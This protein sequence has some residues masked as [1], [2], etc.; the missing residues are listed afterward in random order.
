MSASEGLPRWARMWAWPWAPWSGPPWGPAR[1]PQK[2]APSD[3][4]FRGGQ[5]IV[6]R[7]PRVRLGK[8]GE[9]IGAGVRGL[10]SWA[11]TWATRWAR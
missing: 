9:C 5:V 8:G 6:I 10:P 11:Q 3:N 4:G 1:S 2:E 7:S